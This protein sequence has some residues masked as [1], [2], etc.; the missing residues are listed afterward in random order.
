MKVVDKYVCLEKRYAFK[1]VSLSNQ[2]MTRR[3]EDIGEDLEN[4]LQLK[5]ERLLHFH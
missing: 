5:A 1:E 4:Q 3:I 2:T